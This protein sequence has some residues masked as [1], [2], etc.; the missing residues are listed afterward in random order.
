[1]MGSLELI[2]F[3]KEH[4]HQMVNSLMNDPQTEIDKKYHEQLNGLEVED[5][6]FTVVYDNKIVCA[7]G[8]IPVWD[9]GFTFNLATS[10]WCS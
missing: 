1:M 8:V 3:K 2:Q 9:N 10:H 5:M 6:S 4:A 7:G